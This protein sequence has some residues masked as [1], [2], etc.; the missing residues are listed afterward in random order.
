MQKCSEILGLGFEIWSHGQGIWG[1]AQ[2]VESFG[3]GFGSLAQYS[4]CLARLVGRLAPL[5]WGNPHIVFLL[6]YVVEVPT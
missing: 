6:R 2:T 4:V 1:L 3:T 5:S